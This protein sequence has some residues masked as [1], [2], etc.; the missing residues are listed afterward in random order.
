MDSLLPIFLVWWEQIEKKNI[1]GKTSNVRMWVLQC[2]LKSGASTFDIFL[3]DLF[4]L[5][6]FINII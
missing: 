4:P 2:H 6:N 3:L 5:V 1:E